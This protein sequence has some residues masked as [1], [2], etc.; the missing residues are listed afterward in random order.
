MVLSPLPSIIMEFSDDGDLYQKIVVHQKE[1]TSFS[2]EQIWKTLVHVTMGLRKLHNLN[3]LHR[4][5][6][7]LPSP[8]RAQTSSSVRTA[9]PNWET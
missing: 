3:I 7:V 1:K 2:E 4:D 8:G 5:L 6:K 9:R